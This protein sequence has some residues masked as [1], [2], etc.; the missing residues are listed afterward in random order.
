LPAYVQAHT[1]RRIEERFDITSPSIARETIFHEVDGN[2]AIR[3]RGN[4]LVPFKFKEHIV[5]YLL[6][7]II[8]DFCL[9]KT[10]LFVTQNGTPEGD[11]LTQTLQ[12]SKRDVSFL[13]IDRLSTFKTSS[14]KDDPLLLELFEDNDLSYI[15]EMNF[16]EVVLPS[17]FYKDSSQYLKEYL[18][19]RKN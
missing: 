9:F 6:C 17:H 5:G 7:E 4:W 10:F 8:N 18:L 1:F 15:L 11:R 13:E 3:Y 14:V 2:K 16:E 19:N 12:L